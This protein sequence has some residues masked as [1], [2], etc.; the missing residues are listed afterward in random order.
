MNAIFAL[1]ILIAV[2]GSLSEAIPNEDP[3]KWTNYYS[4]RLL[5]ANRDAAL[6]MTEEQFEEHFHLKPILD[7]Y[8]YQ[9]HQTALMRSQKQVREVNEDFAAGRK[10]W[11]D[12]INEFSNL[13]A[14]EFIKQKTGMSDGR[15]VAVDAGYLE[16]EGGGFGSFPPLNDSLYT[17][18]YKRNALPE[19]YNAVE[20]GLV[21]PVKDQKNC[22]SCA[23][24]A[25]MSCI[26]TCFKKAT[27]V[28]GDYSEQ[29]LLDCAYGRQNGAQGCDGAQPGAYLR[30]AGDRRAEFASE[31]NYPYNEAVGT[32]SADR[33]EPLDQGARITGHYI[34]HR[35]IEDEETMK[36][37][38]YEHGSVMVGIFA[39]GN[40]QNYGGGIYY[41][42]W[43]SPNVKANHA[44]ALVG[45]GTENGKDYWLIKNSWGTGWGENG[46]GKI[47]RGVNMC[48]IG[49]FMGVIECEKKT[50]AGS[51]C[52]D[53]SGWCKTFPRELCAYPKIRQAC[54]QHCGLC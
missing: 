13:P 2:Q 46:F 34:T 4:N 44:V 36:S 12:R 15:P 35:S 48:G 29:Q 1:A 28:F 7:I 40:L 53:S 50:T 22:G 11:F 24:F 8:Q 37:L 14:D 49:E 45:Y 6:S 32:C 42:C 10:T 20:Q 51:A 47:E 19:S 17:G 54:K 27:G 9:T 5:Q 43:D 26:E 23:A 16:R 18:R 31:I 30:W 3:N 41:G 52:S 21:S 33:V 39:D 25:T 38:L